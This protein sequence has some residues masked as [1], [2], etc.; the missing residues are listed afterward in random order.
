MW[1]PTSGN[2][3]LKD[4]KPPLPCVQRGLFSG[5]S[6]GKRHVASVIQ[7]RCMPRALGEWQATVVQHLDFRIA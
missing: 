4:P 3:E 1:L 5:R 7:R 6:P 2:P